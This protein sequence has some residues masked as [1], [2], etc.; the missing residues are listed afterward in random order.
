MVRDSS[1]NIVTLK[2]VSFSYQAGTQSY[3]VLS[4]LNLAIRRGELLAIQGPSGSGKSTLFY[5]IGCLMK[6]TSGGIYFNGTDISTYR[7]LE[8]AQFRNQHVG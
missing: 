8:L 7:E 3:P 6:P 1:Q 5:L 4:G 2:D